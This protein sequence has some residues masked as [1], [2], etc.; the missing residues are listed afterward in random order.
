MLCTRCGK[1]IAPGNAFC[2][3]CGA[4]APTSA[5]GAFH[6]PT[7]APAQAPTPAQRKP[8]SGA[9]PLEPARS[10]PLFLIA[11][12]C[13]TVTAVFQLITLIQGIT[14]IDQFGDVLEM[15]GVSSLGDMLGEATTVIAVVLLLITWM[16]VA[17]LWMTWASGP[18]GDKRQL[19]SSGLQLIRASLLI[20]VI[21]LI[22]L[23]VFVFLSVPLVA[24]INRPVGPQSSSRSEVDMGALTL[25]LVGLVLALVVFYF[26]TALRAVK[27][28]RIANV[29]GRLPGMPSLLLAVVS[30]FFGVVYLLRLPGAGES[31]M[32]NVIEILANTGANLLFCFVIVMFRGHDSSLN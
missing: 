13:L 4:P 8:L 17:G 20:Q 14:A 22:L 24:I 29:T 28:A 9:G 27:M 10:N 23:T 5:G 26:L 32:T 3:G 25:F 19:M 18:R 6:S 12:I 21:P 7:V 31:G 15:F 16:M 30:F 2:T 11:I 1:E